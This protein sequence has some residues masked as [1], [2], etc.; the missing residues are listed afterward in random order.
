[1]NVKSFIGQAPVVFV[2]GNPFQ[3]NLMFASNA[4]CSNL[5]YAP[6]LTLTLDQAGK[7]F[8]GPKLQLISNTHKLLKE[9]GQ[10]VLYNDMFSTNLKFGQVEKQIAK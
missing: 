8:Q 1:M 6:G 2:P 9:F 3:P 5:G 10:I 7:A 4:K